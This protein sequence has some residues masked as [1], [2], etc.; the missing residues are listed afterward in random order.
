MRS[1]SYSPVLASLANVFKIPLSQTAI[2]PSIPLL[3]NQSQT[4]TQSTTNLVAGKAAFSTTSPL[5]KRKGPHQMDRRITLIRYFLHHPLTPRP[6]R[7]SRTR[8]LR[9]WTIQRAWNLYQGERR[10][11]KTDELQRQWQAMNTACEE[12]RTGAG[13]GGW[14][15]RKSMIKTNLFTDMFPIEYGRMQTE[16]PG[17][18][19]NEGWKG[20]ESKRR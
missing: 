9:H 14:L 13:D 12:L 1:L 18:G 8:Y 2:R 16:G 4:P 10:Q 15:F 17:E 19:W 7:F 3:Q 6:L 5:L 11:K 20:G